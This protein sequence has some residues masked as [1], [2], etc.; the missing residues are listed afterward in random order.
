[1]ELLLKLE[2]Y[3][4]ECCVKGK[5]IGFVVPLSFN[6]NQVGDR[7]YGEQIT[8]VLL[9]RIIMGILL[10]PIQLFLS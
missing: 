3:I 1:M 9:E 4:P 10:V 8:Y 7:V 5:K 2:R 6:D